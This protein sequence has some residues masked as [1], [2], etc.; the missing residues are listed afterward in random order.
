VGD[1]VCIISLLAAAAVIWKVR[2]REEERK[3]E[4]E[5]GVLNR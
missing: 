1:A 5:R 4:E 2:E 3:G